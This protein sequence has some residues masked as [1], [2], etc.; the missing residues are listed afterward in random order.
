[1][2]DLGIQQTKGWLGESVDCEQEVCPLVCSI[3]H[4]LMPVE[5]LIYDDSKQFGASVH[6]ITRTELA[7]WK[8]LQGI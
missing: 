7:M 6:L 5:L 4:M 3:V 2:V 8:Y 1:M